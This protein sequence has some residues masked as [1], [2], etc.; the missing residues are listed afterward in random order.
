[1]GAVLERKVWASLATPLYPNLYVFLVG[2]A[3]AGKT[4]AIDAMMEILREI[5][6]FYFSPT[7]VTRASLVDCLLDAK[8]TDPDW[9]AGTMS[10]YH[11]LYVAVDELSAFMETWKEDLVAGLIKFYDGNHYSESRRTGNLHIEIDKP[12]LNVICGTTPANLMKL[13]PDG[14]W[15]QGFTSRVILVWSDDSKER[16]ILELDDIVDASDD[17]KHDIRVIH[18]EARGP[19]TW[20][21]EFHTALNRWRELKDTDG[22]SHPRL[23]DY[24][25]RRRSHLVK[26]AVIACIDRGGVVLGIEDF[27]RAHRWLL[28]NEV[29]MHIIFSAGSTSID[30][31]AFDEIEEFVKNHG[32]P[33]PHHKLL[34]QVSRFIPAHSQERVIRLMIEQRR[35]RI[36]GKDEKINQVVYLPQ[37]K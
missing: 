34:R 35:I 4:R 21:G 23:A 7:S 20:T 18:R 17:L 29:E 14:A 6:E 19:I 5:P 12:N 22:P 11:T 2:R 26:L 15:D 3:A 30:D 36:A 33:V 13:V 8:R 37:D 16:D 32:K 27:N 31:K 24:R 28:E 25:A 9:T 10:E 1:V